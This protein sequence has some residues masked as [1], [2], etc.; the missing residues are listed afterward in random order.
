MKLFVKNFPPN[1]TKRALKALVRSQLDGKHRFWP[2]KDKYELSG[3]DIMKV[4]DPVA[5]TVEHYAVMRIEPEKSALKAMRALNGRMFRGR[6]L[7]AR[8]FVDRAATDQRFRA[9]KKLGESR[10]E[11]KRRSDL[12]VEMNP[13]E[14]FGVEAYRDL[15]RTMD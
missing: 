2:F 11:E 3:C 5:G 10:P 6:I 15:A 13:Q 9:M 12:E 14:D 1:T 4:T 8:K 7:L